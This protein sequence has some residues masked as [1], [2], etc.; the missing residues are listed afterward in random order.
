MNQAKATRSLRLWVMALGVLAVLSA[1]KPPMLL[2][3]GFTYVYGAFGS[4][5]LWAVIL[6]IYSKRM[7]REATY[8]NI[9]VGL[10]AYIA[11]RYLGSS[12]PMLW[13]VTLS[14]LG[15]LIALKFTPPPPL[16]AYEA[17]F[18]ENVS[19][20]TMH[21]IRRIRHEEEEAEAAV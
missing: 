20:E 10:V 3:M 1:I 11:G 15:L 4:I 12:N 16:E 18:E 14:L 21:T 6:G 13:S 7:N 5:F 17:F 9:L 2:A 8:V 19:P